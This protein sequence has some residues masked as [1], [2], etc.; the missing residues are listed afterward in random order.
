MTA[1]TN[2]EDLQTCLEAGMNA[3]VKKPVRFDHLMAILAHWTGIG[4]APTAPSVAASSRVLDPA[5]LEEV[6]G[7]MTGEALE[8]LTLFEE[9]ARA[10]FAKYRTAREAG[11]DTAA[12]DAAHNPGGRLGQ[13]RG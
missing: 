10:A 6:N 9:T 5:R 4:E 1:S 11:D 3:V 2:E 8:I 7:A 13:C 12:M